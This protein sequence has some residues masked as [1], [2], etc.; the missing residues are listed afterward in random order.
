MRTEDLSEIHTLAGALGVATAK[1]QKFL[2]SIADEDDNSF[3]LKA[4]PPQLND[5]VSDLLTR[6]IVV[7]GLIEGLEAGEVI[8]LVPKSFLESNKSNLQSAISALEGVE[9]HIET[10]I[11]QHGGLKTI[12]Y[13]DFQAVTNGG[14]AADLNGPFSTLNK[15][16][17]A[18]LQSYHQLAS[19]LGIRGAKSF[20]SATKSLSELVQTISLDTDEARKIRQSLAESEERAAAILTTM[21]SE[22]DEIARLKDQAANDRKTITEYT[23][24]ST[25]KVTSIRATHDS[26]SSLEGIVGEYETTFKEFQTTLNGQKDEIRKGKAS[27]KEL[28]QR[29]EGTILTVDETIARSEAML[30]SATVAG[31]AQHFFLLKNEIASELRG[32]RRAFYFAIAMLALSAIPLAIYILAPILNLFFPDTIGAGEQLG[33]QPEP[34]HLQHLVQLIGRIA[35]LIPAAWFVSFSARRHASLFKLR[36]HYAY[37]YSMAVSVEGFKK[38]APE[39]ASEVAATVLEQLAFNPAERMD[40]KL[41]DSNGP[42]PILNIILQRLR[43]GEAGEPTA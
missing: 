23:S 43:K 40:A 26:A 30:S 42:A 41:Q 10:T 18:L 12:N 14:Q 32:A 5:S 34:S 24:E 11:L 29:L 33:L 21:K 17:E 39:Y 28:I 20:Q 22:Q 2:S 1:T 19:T 4:K 38:Q 13:D 16:L 25:E 6:A 9:S 31:L 8:D 15:R 35:F 27:V 36:E 3:D 37:K 7:S